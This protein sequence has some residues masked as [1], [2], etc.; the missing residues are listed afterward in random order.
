[1]GSE[2]PATGKTLAIETK[3]AI[4]SN[5]GYFDF[6]NGLVVKKVCDSGRPPWPQN[7]TLDSG[8]GRFV[9]TEASQRP[10]GLLNHKTVEEIE[11]SRI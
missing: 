4:H 9:A 5:S 1:M 6:L 2:V 3:L 7:G 11:I 8:D 10:W